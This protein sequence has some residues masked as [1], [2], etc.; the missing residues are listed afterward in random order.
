MSKIL[1]TGS[2]GT[3][4]TRLCERLLSLDYQVIGID[5]VPNKW[6]KDV[7][8]ITIVRNL[9]DANCF[10]GIPKDIS[11][12]IHLAANARVYNSVVNPDIA[13]ENID[14]TYNILEFC[15]KNNIKKFLFASSREVYG[16]RSL[17]ASEKDVEIN[18]CESPYTASK[19]AGEALVYAYKKCYDLNY[20]VFRFSNV[21]GMYDDTAR[22][23]PLWIYQ[24]KRGEDLRI[25]GRDK[26][27]DFT[28][29]DD[30]IDGISMACDYLPKCETFNLT[31]GQGVKL[32]KIA[33]IIIKGTNSTSNVV[34]ENNREGEI[35]FFEGNNALASDKLGFSPKTDVYEGLQKSIKWY[36]ENEGIVPI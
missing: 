19:I 16:D 22:L 23:V 15:R 32:S 11:T 24:A 5:K 9:N 3:I 4:G 6:N 26:T 27:L 33:E 31:Y 8:D 10:N 20:I 2:S 17:S 18:N 14:I 7:Q 13:K 30:T 12:V 21:Y 35:T 34:F 36:G 29:I 1:V 28:Y 25:F